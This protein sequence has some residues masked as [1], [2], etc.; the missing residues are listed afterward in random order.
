MA[1]Q[2]LPS[3]HKVPTL[4]QESDLNGRGAFYYFR[5]F[6]GQVHYVETSCSRP[7][8]DCPAGVPYTRRGTGLLYGRCDAVR[9]SRLR[10]NAKFRT[11]S[12]V[13]R[14]ARSKPGAD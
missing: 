1:M 5:L 3:L 2:F 12:V 4:T 9:H 10:L 7:G 11:T 14:A 8:H 6:N 13:R